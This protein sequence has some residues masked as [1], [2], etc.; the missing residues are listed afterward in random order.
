MYQGRIQEGVHR[1]GYFR[2]VQWRNTGGGCT[3][4][5]TGGGDCVVRIQV[6]FLLLFLHPYLSILMWSKL[7]DFVK[8]K[9]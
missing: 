2:G 4:V 6:F 5:D 9:N 3:G 8:I 1:G 7:V